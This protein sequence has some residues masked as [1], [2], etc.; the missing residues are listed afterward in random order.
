MLQSSQ[1]LVVALL[2]TKHQ[3][4]LNP[5]E[6]PS[7]VV[8]DSE[9]ITIKV[10][11]TFTINASVLPVGASQEVTYTSSNPPKA[12]INSV[13]TGEGVAEGTANITVASKE[14]TSIN[15]VVQVTVEAAD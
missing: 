13:G 9:T 14:S 6:S 2:T 1:H 4:L 12:K 11:E 7:S 8:V 3:Q 15:K 10:G 5:D